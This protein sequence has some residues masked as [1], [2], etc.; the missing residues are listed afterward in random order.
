MAPVRCPAPLCTQAY[1]GP[2]WSGA[3]FYDLPFL[4]SAIRDSTSFFIRVTGSISSGWNRI[5]PSETSKFV[6]SE[7]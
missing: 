2:A 5:V 3:I 7:E 4:I 1:A 6:S